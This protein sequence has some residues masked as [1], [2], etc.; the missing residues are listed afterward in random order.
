MIPDPPEAVVLV[1]PEAVVLVW[2][3][4]ANL[5]DVHAELGCS[6]VRSARARGEVETTLTFLPGVSVVLDQAARSAR[7][8]DACGATSR[9][10]RLDR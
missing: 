6:E 1:S 9:L 3:H 7:R 5:P 8:C 4:R 10:D 2:R